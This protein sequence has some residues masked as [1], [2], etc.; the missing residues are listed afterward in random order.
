MFNRTLLLG[1]AVCALIAAPL[2]LADNHSE[3]SPEAEAEGQ[4]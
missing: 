4:D 1:A 2:A 3:M